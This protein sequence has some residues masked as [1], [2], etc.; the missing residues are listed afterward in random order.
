MSSF[1]IYNY[2]F[3]RINRR[4]RE[5]GLFGKDS[6]EMEA[7]EAFPPRQQLLSTLLTDDYKSEQ[8]VCKIKFINGRSDKEFIHRFP[9]RPG[10]I[11]KKP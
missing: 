10:L 2:Q 1:A 4:A 7:D 6:L 8:E 11:I 5:Q 9:V 3:A